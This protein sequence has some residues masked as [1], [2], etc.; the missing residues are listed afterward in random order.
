MSEGPTS[1][2]PRDAATWALV[3]ALMMLAVMGTVWAF[4]SRQGVS[5]PPPVAAPV[6]PAPE[7]APPE[8]PAPTEPPP[9]EPASETPAP[10]E[11]GPKAEKRP[12]PASESAPLPPLPGSAPIDLNRATKEQLEALPGIGPALAQRIIDDRTAR[13]PFRSVD[14]LDRVSGIGKKTIDKLRAKV[15]VGP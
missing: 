10:A 8:R 14:D 11:S 13:G 2:R 6:N 7:V 3:G 15:T 9:A 5:T 4:Q 1:V 12:A